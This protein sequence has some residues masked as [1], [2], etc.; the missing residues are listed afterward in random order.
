[1]HIHKSGES[2]VTEA[3]LIRVALPRHTAKR[4]ARLM[5]CSTE[6]AKHWLYYG[7][8]WRRRRELAQALI[9][10]MDREDAAREEARRRLVE[11]AA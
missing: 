1:V 3:A 11:M 10:E 4:L 9:A 7:P 6:T 8:A 5:G 2:T